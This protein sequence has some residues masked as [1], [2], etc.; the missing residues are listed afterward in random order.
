MA[1]TLSISSEVNQANLEELG[2]LLAR[3]TPDLLE[4][5]VRL[6]DAGV[7][8]IESRLV[9][10]IVQWARG[11]GLRTLSIPSSYRNPIDFLR[12][13][14][15]TAY[16]TAAVAVAQKVVTSEGIQVA[17][18]DVR[19]QISRR[20][21]SLDQRTPD[22]F[23]RED[24]YSAISIY[25]H[26]LEYEHW[27]FPEDY[28]TDAR[29]R[30]ATQVSNW[31]EDIVPRMLPPEFVDR[32]DQSRRSQLAAA[33]FEL[34]ENTYLH[35]RK[36]EYAEPLNYGVCG[37]SMRLIRVPYDAKGFLS[38]AEGDVARYFLS[39]LMKDASDAG[40]FFEVTVFD[41]GIGYHRW[42]NAPCNDLPDIRKYRGKSEPETVQS[43]LLKH[44]TSKTSDG[45]GVGLSRVTRILKAL[46]GFVRIRT[47]RTCYY[48]RLDQGPDG[49]PLVLGDQA[50]VMEPAVALRDWFPGRELP[51]A[52]GTSVT[53]CIP[54]T[55]WRR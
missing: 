39:R 2:E 26:P 53:I 5:P 15:L 30:A 6:R 29:L 40:L 32:I 45:S 16:G 3:E 24:G 48:S 17:Q 10:L 8:G 46:F 18:R 13:L 33:T 44:A 1:K 19:D 36:D 23:V 11:P 49:K 21:V 47:G 27:L 28:S 22:M 52:Q 20:L 42:I 50:A 37:L 51:E 35:G 41:S 12:E 38:G 14:C 9:H 43:C 25:G 54:L 31:F 4:L 34:L 55:Q 7:L